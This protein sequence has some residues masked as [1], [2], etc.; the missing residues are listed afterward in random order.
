MAGEIN[1]TNTLVQNSSG[2]IVGQGAFT[3][4]FAGSLIE[5]SNKSYADNVTNLNGELSGKQHTFSGDFVYNND[6]EFRN[7]RSAAFIGTQDTYTLTYTGSGSV[8]DESFTG[9]FTPNGLSDSLGHGEAGMTTMTFTSSGA[10]TRVA[11]A[12][13]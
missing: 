10:V 9:L 2:V 3:H 13:A 5:I 8:T 12:D 4:A 11:A 7:T 6:A 1:T